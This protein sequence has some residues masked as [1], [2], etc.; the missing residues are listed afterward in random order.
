MEAIITGVAVGVIMAAVNTAIAVI[1]SAR[2]KGRREAEQLADNERRV[3][4]LEERAEET[5]ELARLT[6]G[7]CI[8]LGDGM[9]QHGINGEFKRSFAEKKQDALK[10][11]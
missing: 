8:I 11:L 7:T 6:L 10:L 9:V 4:A 5:R 1:T 3:A 2:K